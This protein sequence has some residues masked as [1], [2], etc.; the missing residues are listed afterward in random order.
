MCVLKC[1]PAVTMEAC[2]YNNIALWSTLARHPESRFGSIRQWTTSP[3]VLD[4][5]QTST[6]YPLF[7]FLILTIYKYTTIELKSRKREKGLAEAKTTRQKKCRLR[8]KQGR[9]KESRML[10]RNLVQRELQTYVEV[11]PTYLSWLLDCVWCG[12]LETYLLII[13]R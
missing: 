13:F 8:V 10:M 1:F 11:V 5:I 7:D 6:F 9:G 2:G 3:S 12:L 4:L